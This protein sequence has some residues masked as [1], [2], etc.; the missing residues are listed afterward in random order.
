MLRFL[1]KCVLIIAC[2]VA[3]TGHAEP[4]YEFYDLGLLETDYSE[5]YCIN[6]LGQTVILYEFQGQHRIGIWEVKQGITLIDLPQVAIPVRINNNGQIAGNY[7]SANNHCRGFFWDPIEGFADIGTLGGDTTQV[8]DLNDLGQ[9]VGA[10]STGKKGQQISYGEETHAFVWQKGR[11]KDLGTLP[12]ALGTPTD[13]SSAVAINNL[14]Q[15]VGCS[16]YVMVHKGKRIRGPNQAVIW[17]DN[18][19][20]R[21]ILYQ[22]SHKTE[23]RAYGINDKGEIT[24]DG[25]HPDSKQYRQF[26]YKED[27]GVFINIHGGRFNQGINNGGYAIAEG[28][29]STPGG[30]LR[31]PNGQIIDRNEFLYKDIQAKNTWK[32]LERINGVNNRGEI[33]GKGHTWYGEGHAFLIR[34][35]S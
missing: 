22:D 12:D 25:P 5:A 13:F 4:A 6:D 26:L 2:F 23:S 29:T 18:G 28:S 11:L 31:I 7:T 17:T 20:P 15:I 8:S 16:E 34:P 3:T 32:K 33:V 9:V 19:P 27:S 35:K 24:M 1:F 14:G 30:S 21:E 10:S